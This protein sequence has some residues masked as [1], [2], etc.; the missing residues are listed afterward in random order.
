MAEQWKVDR[1]VKLKLVKVKME[2]YNILLIT[3]Y[4]TLDF[5]QAEV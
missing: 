4:A 2:M 1:N 3:V 5:A